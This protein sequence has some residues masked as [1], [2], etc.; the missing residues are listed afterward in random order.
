MASVLWRPGRAAVTK[1]WQQRPMANRLDSVDRGSRSGLSKLGCSLP[2]VFVTHGRYLLVTA[3]FWRVC[4]RLKRTRKIFTKPLTNGRGRPPFE[5]KHLPL[6]LPVGASLPLWA[7]LLRARVWDF[8]HGFGRRPS[9]CH[10]Q[11]FTDA[12]PRRVCPTW[13]TNGFVPCARST[14][15]CRQSPKRSMGG[16]AGTKPI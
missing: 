15:S 16:V 4:K 7:V 2:I 10:A 9:N 14:R 8:W 11:L 12:V 3:T 1:A 13:P 5:A 6:N